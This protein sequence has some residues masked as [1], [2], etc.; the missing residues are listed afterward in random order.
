MSRAFISW[1]DDVLLPRTTD[2]CTLAW[3][4]RVMWS[5]GMRDTFAGVSLAGEMYRW[6]CHYCVHLSCHRSPESLSCYL[7]LILQT[8][9]LKVSPNPWILLSERI[10]VTEMDMIWSS[11]HSSYNPPLVYGPQVYLK[12]YCLTQSIQL[13]AN[14]PS[15]CDP[16]AVSP[17]LSPCDPVLNTPA[18]WYILDRFNFTRIKVSLHNAG[19]C[20]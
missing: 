14:T 13:F 8:S 20:Q 7:A 15:L 18:S 12:A 1:P 19:R 5:G 4:R 9:P 3:W 16:C 17:N 10:V 11:P 6:S 2:S